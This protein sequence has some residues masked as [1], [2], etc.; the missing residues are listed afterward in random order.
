MVKKLQTS[1]SFRTGIFLLFS[2]FISYI[3]LIVLSIFFSND[4]LLVYV[5][6]LLFTRSTR[7]ST[8]NA[9]FLGTLFLWSMVQRTH[10]KCGRDSCFRWL[11]FSVAFVVAVISSIYPRLLLRF[12][13]VSFTLNSALSFFR[14]PTFIFV[15]GEFLLTKFRNVRCMC[16]NA[17]ASAYIHI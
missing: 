6:F 17:S 4:A 5:M 9:L 1:C 8:L 14:V 12:T 7:S 2:H 11:C 13:I 15:P 3:M 10:S 16:I